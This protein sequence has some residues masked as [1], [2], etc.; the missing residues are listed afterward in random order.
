M[1]AGSEWLSAF[2]LAEASKAVRALR[3]GWCALA[4]QPRRDFHPRVRE[5]KLTRVLRSY[6]ERVT[7]REMGLLGFWGAECVDNEVDFETGEILEERRTDILFAWNDDET[8]ICLVFEFKKLNH[9][10][11][12]RDNYLGEDGLLRFV[13]G[14]YSRQ[15]A[16]AVM[17]GILTAP[18]ANVVPQLR[19]AL[20]DETTAVVLKLCQQEDGRW[21][22]RPSLLFPDD[23]DFDTE[24]R[25]IEELA[26]IHGTIR[27]AHLFLAFGMKE[28]P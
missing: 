15:Q 25:R 27:I 5:E 11:S 20:Q 8:S 6:V 4:A 21:I 26:P 2:P 19:N 12:S 16:V 13:T 9:R 22:R 1:T 23:A 14:S 24:H 17:A 28:Y 10:K 3:Q 7:A 18:E